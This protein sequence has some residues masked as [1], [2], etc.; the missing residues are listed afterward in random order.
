MPSKDRAG[1]I[2]GPFLYTKEYIRFYKLFIV[3]YTPYMY[4]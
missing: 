3:K 4:N 2:A 1:F